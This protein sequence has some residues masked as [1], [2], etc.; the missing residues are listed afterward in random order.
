MGVFTTRIS[1]NLL[2]SNLAYEGAV[3]LDVEDVNE[4]HFILSNLFQN[5]KELKELLKHIN[6]IDSLEID[7]SFS[8]VVELSISYYEHFSESDIHYFHELLL[9]VLH[10]L[11]HNAS[12]STYESGNFTFSL[13][14]YEKKMCMELNTVK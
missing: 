9:I 13:S 10:D 4:I 8:S 14:L 7:Y 11:H 6:K 1:K 5:Q 3:Y 12:Y 2:S